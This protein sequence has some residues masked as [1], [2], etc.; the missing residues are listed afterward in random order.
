[1]L[2]KQKNI[3]I[4]NRFRN[5]LP[6]V[7][8]VETSGLDPENNALL[9]IAI[10]TLT[11]N[12][13]GKFAL[14]E[15]LAFHVEA[16]PGALFD[17]ESLAITN[18]DPGYP[19]RYAIPEHQALHFIFQ[20]IH[21]CLETTGCQR[22]VFVGHNVWFDLAV[23]K[24][25]VKRARIHKTPF[26]NFTVFDTATLAGFIF[27]ETVLARALR[28]AKIS[29]DITKAHSAIYDAQKTAA[30]FCHMVNSYKI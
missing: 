4:A 27:G 15:T 20:K 8:D 21:Q 13:Q 17:P 14:D 5:L 25:A 12:E 7:V 29:F 28:S 26:H 24:A 19:L 3:K 30:L 16:F 23:I 18:I 10:V 1:M 2:P 6:I 9:E 22:A 11:M